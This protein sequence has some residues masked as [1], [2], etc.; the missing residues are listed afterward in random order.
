MD[1][2]FFLGVH[3]VAML[4]VIRHASRWWLLMGK[5]MIKAKEKEDGYLC[6]MLRSQNIV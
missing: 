4:K 6:G 2:I 1:R 3:D 5:H